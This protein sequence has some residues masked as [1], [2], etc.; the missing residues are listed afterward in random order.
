M[1]VFH[2]Q[3]NHSSKEDAQVEIISSYYSLPSHIRCQNAANLLKENGMVNAILNAAIGAKGLLEVENIE[4][5][6]CS[7]LVGYAKNDFVLV[8]TPSADN[9]FSVRPALFLD[10]K[11]T[12]RYIVDG[13]A[14][15]FQAQL[16][17]STKE[18]ARL[19]LLS[20]PTEIADYELRADKR[21]P[22]T[23]PAE[24]KIQDLVCN[25]LIVDIS[26][27]GLR[28]H[29]KDSEDPSAK[30]ISSSLGRECTLRFFLPGGKIRNYE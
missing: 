12:V 10:C 22:C 14:V 18:P 8:T 23:L 5:R 27:I 11:I 20:Y 3:C 9:L 1:F 19:L 7:F 2:K 30:L 29:I 15:A 13:K 24:V 25:A 16:M 21:A 6:F 4:K 28:F 17:K 26:Q